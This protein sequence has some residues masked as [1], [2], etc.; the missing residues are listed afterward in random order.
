MISF[1]MSDKE[2]ALAYEMGT[3][4]NAAKA[5]VFSKRFGPLPDDETHI[6]GAV[7]EIAVAKIFGVQPDLAILVGGDGG[8]DLTYKG[9]TW[10]V[11]TRSQPNSD[12]LI[13]T[14]M[15]DFRADA[16]VLC[17]LF[18]PWKVGVVGWI[19]RK[20]FL[21]R[22]QRIEARGPRLCLP[23]EQMRGMGE[24]LKR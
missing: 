5:G 10:D 6:I 4:R 16:V 18:V 14:D 2:M 22:C 15:S 13:N 20:G 11:K 7:G 17:W 3:R 24:V 12:L 9:W 21:G 1:T 19:S 23:W 8:V